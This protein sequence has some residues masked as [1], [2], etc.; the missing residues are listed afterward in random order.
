MPWV[1]GNTI[2]WD[3]DRSSPSTGDK[4]SD[5]QDPTGLLTRS[6]ADGAEGVIYVALNYRVGMYGFLN[7]GGDPSIFPNAGLQDQRLGLDW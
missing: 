2:N 1:S 4:D 7:G 5:P 6:Q 3:R